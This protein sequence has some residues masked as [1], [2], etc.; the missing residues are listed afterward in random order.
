M[1]KLILLV[2][3]FLDYQIL[4]KLGE[5]TFSE[6]FQAKSLKT[7]ELVAIKLMKEYYKEESEI[8]KLR[9][10]KALRKLSLHKNIIN[11]IE[12]IL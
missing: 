6:V 3:S 11:L 7:G 1:K 10:I 5:G 4:K 12:V 9:E 8:N 2:V